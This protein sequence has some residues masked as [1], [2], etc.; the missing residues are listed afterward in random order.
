MGTLQIDLLGTSFTIQAKEDPVYLE[1][2]L[3][4]YKQTVNQIE[5]STGLKN[6]L[7]LSI[8]TGIM[9]CDELYKEKKKNANTTIKPSCEDLSEAERL[10]LKMIDN[11][12][13]VL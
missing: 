9:I 2:L 1:N 5:N 6:P 12:N 8:L 4:Y 10:T 11:I 7:K 3:T 13:K